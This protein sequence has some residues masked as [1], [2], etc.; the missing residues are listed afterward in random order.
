MKVYQ[1]PQ[2][3]RTHPDYEQS[4]NATARS[5]GMEIKLRIDEFA[6]GK[7]LNWYNVRILETSVLVGR[8]TVL[9][10]AAGIQ[11]EAYVV[12][13]TTPDSWR[14]SNRI[15]LDKKKLDAALKHII[16]HANLFG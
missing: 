14:I 15:L 4:A 3:R 1:I 6:H 12:A 10:T 8:I 16:R 2:M 5:Q 13:R 7:R 11:T 9:E